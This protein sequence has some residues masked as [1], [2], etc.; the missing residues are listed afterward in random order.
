M[1]FHELHIHDVIYFI[2]LCTVHKIRT[3]YLKKFKQLNHIKT[4]E[5]QST[6]SRFMNAKVSSTRNFSTYLS[7]FY[8]ATLKCDRYNKFP[9]LLNW[10]NNWDQSQC[11][12][13]RFLYED[14]SLLKEEASVF[15]FLHTF[16][17]K[18]LVF[19]SIVLHITRLREKISLS[20]SG[21]GDDIPARIG[22]ESKSFSK[23]RV[24]PHTNTTE[25]D[26]RAY[27]EI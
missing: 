3:V 9:R 11:I 17:L 10:L 12:T 2:M 13:H 4:K 16:K 8:I 25:R 26:Y 7:I 18:T 5:N 22:C 23:R 6:V 15:V 27:R 1:N 14:F 21:V 24:K 19:R 20:Q